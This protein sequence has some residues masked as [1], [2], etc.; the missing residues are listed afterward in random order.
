M[1]LVVIHNEVSYDI[2]QPSMSLQRSG[3]R[4]ED[5]GGYFKNRNRYLVTPGNPQRC[6]SMI[7]K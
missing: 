2:D 5:G 1:S 6:N 3:S 7:A 4:L